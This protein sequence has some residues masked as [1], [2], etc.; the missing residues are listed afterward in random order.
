MDNHISGAQIIHETR[1]FASII[2]RAEG[3]VELVI[4]A[5][6]EKLFG[7]SALKSSETCFILTG[8]ERGVASAFGAPLQPQTPT[9]TIAQATL[10]AGLPSLTP[11][12]LG[13]ARE[14]AAPTFSL[15]ARLVNV[16]RAASRV[17]AIQS[18]NRS[19]RLGRV[20][21]LDES[22][23]ARTPGVAVRD[24]VHTIHLSVRLEK[25]SHRGFGGGKI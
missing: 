21:H 6:F 13:S 16:E 8:P 4:L 23:A 7:I 10:P 11:A 22:E 18:R 24:Q 17:G 3:T 25:R 20:R 12:A 1:T 2:K 5:G 14:S 19:I 15:R 9:A